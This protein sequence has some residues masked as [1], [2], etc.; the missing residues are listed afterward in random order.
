LCYRLRVLYHCPLKC[1]GRVVAPK[2]TMKYSPLRAMITWMAMASSRDRPRKGVRGA[3]GTYR[4]CPGC[5]CV[6]VA[7]R[8]V[9]ATTGRAEAWGWIPV[10]ALSRIPARFLCLASRQK[11]C[12]SRRSRFSWWPRGGRKIPQTKRPRSISRRWRSSR[13][14]QAAALLLSRKVAILAA[15]APHG[16]L[17]RPR[18]QSR[19]RPCAR[20]QSRSTHEASAKA[21]YFSSLTLLKAAASGRVAARQKSCE[22]SAK[23]IYFSSLTI[24]TAAAVEVRTKRP[25]RRSIS[26]RWRSSRRPQAAALLL[27]SKVTKRPRRRTISALFYYCPIESRIKA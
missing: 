2:E 26:R 12:Y 1:S 17:R 10:S 6:H 4:G 19:R 9:K 22:A 21:I 7:I 24:P 3:Q 8:N 23:A 15:Y 11:A 14:P 20:R 27:G 13:R 16:G 25:R 5:V 18:V